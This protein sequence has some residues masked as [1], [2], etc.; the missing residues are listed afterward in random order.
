MSSIHKIAEILA[1]GIMKTFHILCSDKVTKFL[2]FSK[3]PQFIFKGERERKSCKGAESL[4]FFGKIR[5][6]QFPGRLLVLLC[7]C[8]GH[9]H[10]PPLWQ[11]EK[12]MQTKN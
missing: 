12:K 6:H 1:F 7:T 3:R 4:F 9:P 8:M 5:V 2:F 10:Q 11:P